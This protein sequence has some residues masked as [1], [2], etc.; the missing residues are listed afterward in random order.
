MITPIGIS[1]F[2][3]LIEYKDSHGKPYMFIDKS[4]FAGEIIDGA[5]VT[6]ITRPRRFGKTL[7]MSLLHH[8]F[9]K[10][11][12]E[13]PTKHLFEHLE[14]AKHPNYMQ[15]QGQHPVIFLSFKDIKSENFEA[16]FLDIQELMQNV[17]REHE[18]AIMSSKALRES[19]K[20][21]YQ[22]FLEDSVS[23]PHIKTSLKNLIYYLYKAYGRKPIVLIDEYDTPIQGAYLNKHYK[24]MIAF[25]RGFLSAGLK[26]NAH[27]EKA[28]LTGILRVSKESIFSGL[29]NLK[30]Y[31]LLH[32]RYGEF[33]GFTEEE[34]TYL[35]QNAN[36][37]HTLQAVTDWYN[38]YN[39]GKSVIYNP[40]SII[41]YIE[42]QGL[43]Q[44]YWINT[45]DNLLLKKLFIESSLSFKTQFESLLQ[46]KKVEKF[47]NENLA[48]ES[49]KANE[50]ALWTV[51]F[52]SGYLKVMHAE[53]S[54]Q[55]WICQLAIPN[56][57]VRGLL[58]LFIA[59]WL[60]GVD[61]ASVFN[62]FLNEF[63]KGNMEYFEERLKYILL[64]TCSVHDVSGKNPEKFYHGFLLGLLSG[65]DPKQYQIESNKE[66]GLGRY[67]ILIAP[68]DPHQLGIIIELKS[69]EK[70]NL[71][72]LKE[73]AIQALSQIEA[74]QYANTTTLQ[75]ITSLLKIGIAFSGKE[76]A[77]AHAAR[78]A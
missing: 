67:D 12:N 51:L 77:I 78:N 60:S 26:D 19:Y 6:L 56:Y 47:L 33:F 7:N 38:G 55:G 15:Y 22:S 11:I 14:I 40:W 24:K 8:F 45:S 68:R 63:L 62:E 57:E 36:L 27:L 72:S 21:K 75:P 28:V 34:V 9:A 69:I 48:F 54:I 59:E 18:T 46:G 20:K 13:K 29:N 1:D 61:D 70:S 35:L 30:V 76:L 42:E 31:S 43:L 52:M 64:Q 17:Y 2:R 49:L 39:I 53:M 32:T 74:K 4:M 58:K 37:A 71:K 66:A 44:P 73:S 25:I 41:N 10:T 3:T 65:I 50:G 5:H 23:V 16:S